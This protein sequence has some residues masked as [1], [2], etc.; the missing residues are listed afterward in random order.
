M[1]TNNSKTNLDVIYA[2]LTNESLPSKEQRRNTP[3]KEFTRLVR[4][5][6]DTHTCIL[7]FVD[8]QEEQVLRIASSSQ[9]HEFE[10][11]LDKK[12]IIHQILLIKEWGLVLK[13]PQKGMSMK[14]TPYKKTV[15]VL[16]I[17][18]FQRNSI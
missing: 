1:P 13:L 11:Y 8:L 17:L 7:T 16:Q 5:L 3:L 12:R 14:L 4:L 9:N 2:R 15:A 6:T 10:E 18:E